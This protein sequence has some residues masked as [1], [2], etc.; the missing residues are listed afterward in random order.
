MIERGENNRSRIYLLSFVIIIAAAF[1]VAFSIAHTT[2][3]TSG[4]CSYHGG[5]NCAAGPGLYG[6]V[7]CNDGWTGSSVSYYSMVECSSY[8]SVPSIPTIPTCPLFSTYDYLSRSCKCMTGYAVKNGSCV[9][10]NS[11]CQDELGYSSYYDSL[12]NACKCYAGNIISGGRCVN[13]NSYCWDNYGYHSSYDSLSKTCECDSGYTYNSASGEC[14]SYD[15][16]CKNEYGYNAEYN[17]LT[18]KCGCQSGYVVNS[19]G[20]GCVDGDSYCQNLYGYHSSYDSIGKSCECDVGYE[21]KNGTC[22][23]KEAPT[24]HYVPLPVPPVQQAKPARVNAVTTTNAKV[25]TTTSPT[26]PAV[27]RAVTA[28]PQAQWTN[29]ASFELIGDERLRKCAGFGCE[30][31]GVFT[32]KAEVVGQD[33]DWYEVKITTGNSEKSGWFYKTLIPDSVKEYFASS[34]TIVVA[35]SSN[36]SSTSQQ[37]EESL[38]VK[39]IR[40]LGL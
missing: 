11:I 20:S 6:Q 10:L 12:S 27:P 37:K 15:T 39:I 31:E 18:G 38:W 33:G 22:V 19:L 34:S 28:S 4:A 3:A 23:A 32:G 9:S 2:L 13:A 25:S 8:R 29:G 5:V 30:V 21:L 36:S 16:S 26:V 35:S 1:L 24:I 14:V 17:Y 40:F 7:I